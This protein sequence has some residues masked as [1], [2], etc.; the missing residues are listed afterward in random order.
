MYTYLFI[1]SMDFTHSLLEDFGTVN[2]HLKDISLI[3][4]A[5][6]NK[7]DDIYFNQLGNDIFRNLRYAIYSEPVIFWRG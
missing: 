5:M 3:D 4:S 1:H 7:F 6:L 2:V